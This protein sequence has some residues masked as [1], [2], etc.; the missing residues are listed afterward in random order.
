VQGVG[1]VGG[2][3]DRQEK[4]VQQMAQKRILVIDDS[5]AVAKFL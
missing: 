3:A 2:I 5:K 4:Q 1:G